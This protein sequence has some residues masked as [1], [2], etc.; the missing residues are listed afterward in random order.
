MYLLLGLLVAVLAGSM[1]DAFLSNEDTDPADPADPEDDAPGP[2]V[3]D[4]ELLADGAPEGE[5][6]EQGAPPA[7]I[8]DADPLDNHPLANGQPAHEGPDASWRDYSGDDGVRSSDAFPP[9]DAPPEGTVQQA[10]DGGETLRG[11]AGDDLLTGGASADTLLGGPGNDVMVANG[12]GDTLN[13]G[14]GDD[15]LIGGPGD[16][17]LIG[18]WGDDVLIAGGGSNTLM[19]GAGD[20]LLVGAIGP[21]AAPGQNFLNGGAGDDVLI[22]GG[23]D[24]LHGGPG[25]DRFVLGDWIGPGQVVTIM[26]YTPGEDRIELAINP[27]AHPDPELTTAPDPDDAANALI[28]LDGEVIARVLGGA[29][30]AAGDIDLVADHPDL[31]RARSL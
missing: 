6:A 22:G 11:G 20:D 23:N 29:G 19:G 25:T 12:A 2:T 24:V 14:E 18:G 7:M 1:A 4:L 9:G 13:G 5:A 3:A 16:D 30:L 28:V 10:G 21:E 8:W 17:V 31:A 26:D 15:V 27:A